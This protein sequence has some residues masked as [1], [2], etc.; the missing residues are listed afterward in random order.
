MHSSGSILKTYCEKVRHYLDDPDLDA[1]YDDN[2][3]VRFFLASAM[4]D[5]LSRVSMMSDNQIVQILTLAVKTGTQHYRLPPT[6]RQ[7]MRVGLMNASTGYWTE[8][9][10]PR[11]RFNTYGNGW[12]LEGNL[13]SFEPPPTADRD[14]TVAYI[15]SGDVEA[16][17]E[18]GNH[19]VLHANG[20]FTMPAN[21][22]LGSVDKRENAYVGCYLRIFGSGV[23]DE[24]VVSQHAAATRVLTLRTAATNAAGSYPY[25]VVPFLLEP[26]IDA[27]SLSAAMR[28]GTGRKITGAQMQLLTLSYKSAIKTAHDLIGNMNSRSGKRFTGATVDNKNLFTF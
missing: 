12:A 25:E 22:T 4:N 21:V 5:V 20:T 14:M 6:V 18:N 26:M 24:L 2:Y 8:D 1:K 28:A 19:G 16:H 3:L 10:H 7:I 15:P 27:I 17:Y 13:I 23:T 11:N 9:F